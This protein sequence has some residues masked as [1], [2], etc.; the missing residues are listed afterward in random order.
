MC[1]GERE[2]ANTIGTPTSDWE[3]RQMTDGRKS[4]VLDGGE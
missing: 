2:A 3:P 4:Q 1:A